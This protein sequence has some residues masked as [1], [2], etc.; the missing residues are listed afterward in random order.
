MLI[1]YLLTGATTV[2]RSWTG[3]ALVLMNLSIKLMR[4]RVCHSYYH[5]DAEPEWDDVDGVARFATFEEAKA[6]YLECLA[7]PHPSDVAYSVDEYK[8][9]EDEYELGEEENEY[10]LG[11]CLLYKEMPITEANKKW[12]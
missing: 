7:D 12:W 6:R 1:T 8:C 2:Q 9:D 11:E 5:E 10:E 3:V 4:Y